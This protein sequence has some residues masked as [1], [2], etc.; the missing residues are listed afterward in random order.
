MPFIRRSKVKVVIMLNPQIKQL[1]QAY[2]WPDQK[3]EVPGNSHGWCWP[4]HRKM[5]ER[6]LNPKT[7]IILELGTWLGKSTRLLLN[8]APQATVICVDHWLGSINHRDNKKLRTM[9]PTL[10][11]TFLV[12]LWD[13]RDRVVPLRST[14]VAALEEIHR[15]QIV[16][17][18][19]YID[20]GHEYQDVHADVSMSLRFFPTSVICG[21]D[22]NWE[23]VRQAVTEI[24]REYEK[25]FAV[26]DQRCWWFK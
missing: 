16:P 7:S 17:D 5:F 19:I 6:L 25:P 22:W 15:R 14:T 3:P 20:A 4:V 18:L 11:E 10:Y 2:P 1:V 13:D 24:A 21:D 9:L 26:S 8:M 12:N 23:G